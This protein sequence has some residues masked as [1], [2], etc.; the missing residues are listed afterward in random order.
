M[1][2]SKEAEEIA[3]KVGAE[4]ANRGY[5]LVYGAEKDCCSLST[6]AAKSAK[7]IEGTTL[8]VTYGKSKKVWGGEKYEP[9]IVVPSGLGRGGGREFV[10]ALCCD[11]IIAIGGGSGT[12][13]EIAC[14]YQANIPVVVF[15]N[16]PGW[17]KDLAGTYLD[18]RERYVFE[19]VTTA[20]EAVELAVKLAKEYMDKIHE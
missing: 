11:A 19:P 18:G 8:A 6:I 15:S 16:V 5:I 10:L 7:E 13:N 4:I 12:L 20:E 14:A 1:N 3:K 2:Y 17:A 9:S